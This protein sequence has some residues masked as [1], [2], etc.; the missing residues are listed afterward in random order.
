VLAQFRDVVT[1]L[2]MATPLST[3]SKMFELPI[4]SQQRTPPPTDCLPYC[5]PDGTVFGDEDPQRVTFFVKKWRAWPDAKDTR[6]DQGVTFFFD[7]EEKLVRIESQV[8]GIP[9]RTK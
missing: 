3:I 6:K 8:E 4:G 2:P 1:H 5:F 9:N 7:E